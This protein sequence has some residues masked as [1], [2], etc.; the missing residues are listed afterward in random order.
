MAAYGQALKAIKTE[1]RGGLGLRVSFPA[2]PMSTNPFDTRTM[3]YLLAVA[4][5]GSMTAAAAS[6]GVAQPA[7]SQALRRLDISDETDR[8]E[9]VEFYREIAE[10]RAKVPDRLAAL[11]GSQDAV[12][13]SIT[14]LSAMGGQYWKTHPEHRESAS[15]T[16]RTLLQDHDV[17]ITDWHNPRDIPLDQ[18]KFGLDEYTEHLITFMDNNYTASK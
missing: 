6:L 7:L 9:S 10:G 5:L 16:L 8:A 15:R 13:P 4:D 12:L 11:S 17:Y 14:A 2:M 3:R 1:V 18:G